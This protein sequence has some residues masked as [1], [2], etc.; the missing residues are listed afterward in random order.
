MSVLDRDDL[1]LLSDLVYT[2]DKEMKMIEVKKNGL[3]ITYIVDSKL[4]FKE[5]SSN[6]ADI[7]KNDNSKE[8]Y[9]NSFDQ[10][11]LWIYYDE[12]VE[13]KYNSIKSNIRSI[14]KF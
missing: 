13:K 8:L 1:N 6:I 4:N 11:Q 14:W 2:I 7:F 12:I 9:N 5:M 3:I 10:E